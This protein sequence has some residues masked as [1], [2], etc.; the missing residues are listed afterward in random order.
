MI[1]L[2]NLTTPVLYQQVGAIRWTKHNYVKK[3]SPKKISKSSDQAQIPANF[4]VRNTGGKWSKQAADGDSE[5]LPEDKLWEICEKHHNQILPIMTEK[6]HREM[7]QEKA[8]PD[9]CTKG[10]PSLTKHECVLQLRHKGDK[11]TR[12]KSPVSTIMFTRL[13]HRDGNVFTRLGERRK[14]VHSRLGPEV[15]LRHRHASERRS[16]SSNRSAEDPNHRKKDARSLICIYVT[17]SSECQREIEEEWYAADHANRSQPARTK[18]AYFSEEEND[19][20]GH[21]KSQPKKH[22]VWFDKLPPESIDNYEMLRKA[23]L[24]NFSQQ[25]KYIKDPVEIHH[26]KQKE[27]ESTEAF[28]ERFK[29]ESMHANE[30]PKCMRI[31]GFM[32]GIT[33]PD[34]IKKLNDNIPKYRDEMINVTTS[35]IRGGGGSQSVKKE[36]S[37]VVETSQCGRMHPSEEADRG[38]SQATKEGGNPQQRKSYGDLH[39]PTLATNDKEKDHP[40]LL[41]GVRNLFLAPREKR[42]TR[43][44]N[45]DLS[46]SRRASYPPHKIQA[47]PSTAH[48]MLKFPIEGGIVTIRSNTVIPAECRMVTG[49]S[50]GPPPQEP[51]VTEGIKMAIHLEHDRRFKVQ[52]GTS[53][54]YSRRMPAHKVKKKRTRIGQEQRNPRGS[55]QTYG[56]RNHEGSTLP[57]LAFEPSHDA[58]K[59]YHQIQMAKEDEEKTAFHTNQWVFCYTKMSFGLKNT[60]AT[61][62]QLVDK[63]FEKQIG[64]NLKVYVDDL[65]IKSHAEHEILRDVEETFR[66]LKRINMKL[67]RKNVRSVR[68]KVHSWAMWSACKESRHVQIKLKRP[69]MLIRGQILADF[70]AKRPDE[71]DLRIETPDEEVTLEPC[72]L[73][74]DG[75]SCLEG[76][77]SPNSLLADC[78]QMG[79]KNLLAK[80]DSRLM[81]NQING[82]Y[83]AKEQSM[84]QYL[85]KSKA[86]TDNFKMFSIEQVPQSQR[87]CTPAQGEII[88]DNEKQFRIPIQRLVRKAQHQATVEEVLHVL[89]AHRTMIKT[90]N[91]DTPFSL[92]YGTKAVIPIETEM[93]SLRC[94]KVNQ[95]KNNEGI[96]LNLDILEERSEK[97]ALREAKSKAKMEKYYNARVRSTTF[98][99][100]DFVYHSNEA[101]YAKDNGKLGP[102]WEGPYEVMK[103]LRNGAYKLRNGSK[104]ILPRTTSRI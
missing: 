93:P 82:S 63:A 60:G 34:I 52:I 94:T 67:N 2:I 68:K 55:Y 4:V 90:R 41:R 78:K 100:R 103:A 3:I 85:E 12:Q 38:G 83:E 101:S 40:K 72:T 59:G 95:A 89:W 81:A 91:G 43:K 25:K 64:Q 29:S 22:R 26:I 75:S 44:P 87:T 65:V 37:A 84:I 98:R 46:G 54:E 77:R 56:S 51:T 61:Y 73:F 31:Y 48:R 32:H 92:T 23:F 62:Q 47:V 18:E 104:D 20:G 76:I 21:W 69:R 71:E 86:L 27:G 10:H 35:F 14:N 15:A 19:Q 50:S 16:A 9:H 24:G 53:P 66:N 58:C 1:S 57:R 99:P 6:I 74:T 39:G 30:A 36:S 79:V 5:Y 45:C 11:P 80:V 49:A 70:I 96:L 7:L 42:W 17:C 33:N 8:K 88:S 97:A 28:M 102:K 13:G